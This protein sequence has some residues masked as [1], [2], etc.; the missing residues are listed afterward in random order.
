MNFHEP[1]AA[2]NPAADAWRVPPLTSSEIPKAIQA[3]LRSYQ[4]DGVSWLERLR[5]MHLNGIL[6]DDMG[7]GKT[8]QA[9]IAVTQH[10][11]ENPK[12]LSIVVCPTSLVYNW[13]EEFAKFNPNIESAARRW[14]APSEKSC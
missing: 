2:E 8:L 5:Q 7:L 13:K 4:I 6:A 11:M 3:T 10:K 12:A 1:K 9:I 14:H